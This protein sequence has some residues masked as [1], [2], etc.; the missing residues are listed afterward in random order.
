MDPSGSA[1]LMPL[2]AAARLIEFKLVPSAS[3]ARGNGQ[4]LALAKPGN[5]ES[6]DRPEPVATAFLRG[7]YQGLDDARTEFEAK[8]KAAEES[9]EERLA[10]ERAAWVTEQGVQLAEKITAAVDTLTNDIGDSVAAILAP[11]LEEKLRVRIV[12]ELLRSLEK[13]LKGGRPATL[14]ISG[15]DDLLQLLRQTLGAS[16]SAIEFEAT[17]AVDVR[18]VADHTIIETQLEA[19]LQRISGRGE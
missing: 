5:D 17:D 9:F 3:Q 14:K 6:A 19:W 10:A 11:F 16:S 8:L 12:E 13:V 15:P 4:A 1:D 2:P 7:R 18:V